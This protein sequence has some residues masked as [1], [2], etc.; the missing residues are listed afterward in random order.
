MPTVKEIQETTGQ[1]INLS[2]CTVVLGKEKREKS[3]NVAALLAFLLGGL[4]IHDF[5][6]GRTTKGILMLVF[7]WSFIPMIIATFEALWLLCISNE[8]F[9]EICAR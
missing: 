6:M 1:T 8:R 5:Y 2:N 9:Q 7:C 4:G 3:K